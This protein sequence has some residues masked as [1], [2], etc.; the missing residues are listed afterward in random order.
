MA[1]FALDRRALVA[2]GIYLVL[3]GLWIALSDRMLAAMV[4][5]PVALT[6]YQTYKGWAFVA[7]MAALAYVLIGRL[8][9]Q[10]TA[11]R[12]SGARLEES[13]L[14]L[15]EITDHIDQIFYLAAPDYSHFYFV[16]PAYEHIWGRSVAEL[17]ARPASWM[18]GV[19]P[20][21][22]ERIGQVVAAGRDSGFYEAV[23]RVQRP[24]GTLRWV[25]ARAFE[26]R[27]AS[28]RAYRV[29]GI[30]DDVTARQQAEEEIRGLARTLESRVAERTA[31][32]EQANRELEAFS[33][34][35]SH[36]L[37]APLRAINGFAHLVADTPGNQL[38]PDARSMLERIRANAEHMA[39]LIEDIL[40]F[41][42]VGRNE[43]RR[44]RIDMAALVRGIVEEMQAE[45]PATRIEIGELPGAHGDPTMLRQVWVNLIGNALKFSSKRE[46]PRVEIGAETAAD[47]TPAWFVRDNGAGF[48]MAYAARL[49]GVFQ[50]LH[51]ADDFPGTGAGLAIVKRIVMRHGG[52]IS[53][54]SAVD[55]GATFRFTLGG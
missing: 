6:T 27:D 24:D 18:E 21:D 29:T 35:V 38:S 11:L 43:M 40:E 23:Y 2:A 36:D 1:P 19:V 49:F 20:E 54:E 17:L 47:G 13:E 33:Y 51:R 12:I 31:A 30:I 4:S 55:G 50:R 8:S 5:D 15:R 22:R 48:D 45:Y 3:G 7:V 39:E 42:R 14:R 34:S 25:H 9:R 52:N 37:R 26:L 46:T 28:G 44:D 32:L 41:S 53:A 16:S 10:V